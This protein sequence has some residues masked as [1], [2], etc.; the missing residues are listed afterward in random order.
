MTGG[1]AYLR[2]GDI[3]RLTGMSLRNV[4]RWIAENILPCTNLRRREV[5]LF[6]SQCSP[7]LVSYTKPKRSMRSKKTN[8][9]RNKIILNLL[10]MLSWNR[11]NVYWM[12]SFPDKCRVI[13]FLRK[14]F[15]FDLIDLFGLVW[16]TR[17]G[18]A[19]GRL[20]RQ[21]W[22]RRSLVGGKDVFGDPATYR[23]ERHAR[24]TGDIA[25]A[26]ICR[27]ARH[28]RS[29]EM[30]GW[31]CIDRTLTDAQKFRGR[32]AEPAGVLGQSAR[33]PPELLDRGRGLLKQPS[34]PRDRWPGR[35]TSE[36]GK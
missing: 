7:F 28:D 11:W 21:T 10:G 1:A 26:E 2:A 8:L 32:L 36:M 5:C 3:V 17:K 34:S 19:Q 12:I 31:G 25:S 35:T 13:L 30:P 15:C 22:R 16:E 33:R 24:K 18:G 14:L 4:R 20:W 23:S 29:S 9:R 6:L 27:S